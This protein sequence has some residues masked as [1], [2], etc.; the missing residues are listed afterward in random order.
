M[1]ENLI[2]LTVHCQRT[3]EPL[4]CCEMFR[5][6]NGSESLIGRSDSEGKLRLL[7]F[8]RPEKLVLRCPGYTEKEIESNECRLIRMVPNKLVGFCSKL[9]HEVGEIVYVYCNA[10]VAYVAELL[11]Y[12]QHIEKVCDLGSYTSFFQASID[13]E[14]PVAIG[15]GAWELSFQFSIP[16]G[17]H[18]GLYGVHLC[19]EEESFCIPIVV[20]G[21]NE[22]ASAKVLV[23]TSDSTWL[24]YNMWGGQEPISQ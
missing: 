14:D 3:D 16:V 6:V 21:A 13:L 11:R 20:C 1:R 17:A 15:F 9:E 19:S 7:G 10:P 22:G 23:L 12:G 4:G 5:V 18:P 8:E 24:A 2:A